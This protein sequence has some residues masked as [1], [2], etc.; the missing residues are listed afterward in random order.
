MP[1]QLI[2]NQ[3]CKLATQ[4]KERIIISSNTWPKQKLALVIKGIQSFQGNKMTI[5]L[6]F[7][8]SLVLSNVEVPELI[9]TSIFV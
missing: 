2:N 9:D 7:L 8:L 3:N 5:Q 1:T 6:L 4:S